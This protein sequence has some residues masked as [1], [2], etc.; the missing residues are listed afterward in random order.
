MLEIDGLELGMNWTVTDTFSTGFV[1]ELRSTDKTTDAFYNGSGELIEADTSSSDSNMSY[2]LVVDWMPD[3]GTGFTTLHVDYVFRENDRASI[4]GAP[5]WVKDIPNYF[6]DEKLLN[7]RFSWIND[8]E[9]IEIGLWGKNLLDNRYTGSA[10]GRT[11]DILGTPY[12][13]VNRGLEAG[14][15][16]QYSF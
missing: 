15:D 1:T 8:D 3:L 10:G 14:I 6:D 11:Q 9:N 4:I 2:T 16:I 12:T 7:A 5:E 13:S